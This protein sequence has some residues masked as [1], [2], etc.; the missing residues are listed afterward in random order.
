MEKVLD[1]MMHGMNIMH[2]AKPQYFDL[3]F[4]KAK[5]MY[6]EWPGKIYA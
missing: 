3:A 1:T 4:K 2:A 5:S 6:G